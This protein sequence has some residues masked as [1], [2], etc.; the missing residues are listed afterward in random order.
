MISK[1]KVYV[2]CSKSGSFYRGSTEAFLYWTADLKEAH[3]WPTYY[4]AMD[5]LQRQ[6]LAGSTLRQVF[7]TRELALH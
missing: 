4:E 5:F 6:K 2:L 1:D 7:I 3:V